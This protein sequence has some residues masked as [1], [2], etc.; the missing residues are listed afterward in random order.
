MNKIGMAWSNIGKAVLVLVIIFIMI[1]GFSGSLQGFFKSVNECTGKQGICQDAPCDEFA[2]E[3]EIILG[4]N[5]C[6][7]NQYCCTSP[8][9]R[10]ALKERKNDNTITSEG[11]AALY[12]KIEGHVGLY[13]HGDPIKLV[14]GKTY[15]FNVGSN[16]VT[17]DDNK[18]DAWSGDKCSIRF[19][20]DN[21][22][23]PLSNDLEIKDKDGNVVKLFDNKVEN[24]K[25]S[26]YEEFNILFGQDFAQER[27]FLQLEVVGEVD[28]KETIIHAANFGLK[29]E[30][31]VRISGV[32]GN[33]NKEEEITISCS[34]VDCANSA[35]SFYV[36]FGNTGTLESKKLICERGAMV[37]G[38]KLVTTTFVDG[39]AKFNLNKDNV[40]QL[41][42][43]VTESGYV[44]SNLCFVVTNRQTN[45]SFTAFSQNAL[46]IDLSKPIV[47]GLADTEIQCTDTGSG[48]QTYHYKLLDEVKVDDIDLDDITI[49][50]ILSSAFGDLARRYVAERSAC[51]EA[52]YSGKSSPEIKTG[53]DVVF[54]NVC[55]YATDGAGNVG[56]T[57]LRIYKNNEPLIRKAKEL[58]PDLLTNI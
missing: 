49:E 3:Q 16:E 23:V 29:I 17:R 14:T 8:A 28:G 18:V 36:P 43:F 5:S 42:T 4:K 52:I 50:E 54:A 58:I 26:D 6:S 20:K 35:V 51:P 25:C 2:L 41:G 10:Q 30:N 55:V 12:L 7:E 27:L 53:E 24:K 39:S 22:L 46:K 38:Q 21:K 13:G 33:W 9:I 1:F 11:E 40:D 45:N 37:E 19:I 56:E 34:E 31:P 57:K 47:T 32:S 44:D 15:Q 48:C